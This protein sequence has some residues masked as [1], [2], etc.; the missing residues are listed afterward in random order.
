MNNNKIT[1]KFTHIFLNI[2]DGYNIL[3]ITRKTVHSVTEI[4][5][6]KWNAFFLNRILRLLILC[7]KQYKYIASNT[8]HEVYKSRIKPDGLIIEKWHSGAK[9]HQGSVISPLN[10]NQHTR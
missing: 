10:I 2:T 9:D 8:S 7:C 1:I 3:D 5:K 6:F 4:T